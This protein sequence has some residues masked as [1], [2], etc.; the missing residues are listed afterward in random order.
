MQM[1]AD[2]STLLLEVTEACWGDAMNGACILEETHGP[3]CMLYI[4]TGLLLTLNLLQISRTRVP[5]V[6][7]KDTLS[8]PVSY[9]VLFM[10]VRNRIQH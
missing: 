8:I 3:E 6:F 7:C 10:S 4:H 5:E 9:Q 2:I 1:C